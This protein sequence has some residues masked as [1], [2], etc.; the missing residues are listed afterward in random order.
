MLREMRLASVM[1]STWVMSVLCESTLV[2]HLAEQAG[3]ARVVLDQEQRRCSVFRSS[4]L[5]LLRQLGLASARS[6]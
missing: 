4:A 6:R 1:L 3:V 5:L 2:E